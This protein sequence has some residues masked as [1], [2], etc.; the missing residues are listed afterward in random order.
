MHTCLPVH[1][2]GVLFVYC[3]HIACLHDTCTTPSLTLR[4]TTFTWRIGQPPVKNSPSWSHGQE[5]S[6][7]TYGEKCEDDTDT[8]ENSWPALPSSAKRQ[9][10]ISKGS[11]VIQIPKGS[12]NVHK[13]LWPRYE[14]IIN[15][16]S[17][18]T[19]S[20]TATIV[21]TAEQEEEEEKKI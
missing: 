12:K 8:R 10:P 13:P 16:R 11:E 9:P 20:R 17:Q 15:K 6:K 7:S 14:E 18:A 2:L 19:I 21:S 4:C 5:E 1:A 3:P